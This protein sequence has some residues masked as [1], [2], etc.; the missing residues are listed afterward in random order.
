MASQFEPIGHDYVSRNFN[1]RRKGNQHYGKGQEPPKGGN[2]RP[3]AG[4][5][6]VPRKPKP[7]FP[8][9]PSAIKLK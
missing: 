1:D 5:T 2:Y 8:A 9:A 4:G 6:M 3:D 7:K